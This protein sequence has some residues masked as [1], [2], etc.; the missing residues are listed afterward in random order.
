[1]KRLHVSI[2][3]QDL[4]ASVRFYTAFFDAEPTLLKDDYAKWILDDPRVNFVIEPGTDKMGVDHLGIQ[5]ETEAELEDISARLA[6]AEFET[7]DQ[8]DAICCYSKADKYW[9]RDPQGLAWETFYTFGTSTTY[10]KDTLK[11]LERQGF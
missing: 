1:M 4:N 6:V 9:T 2:R 10:G 11:A 7:M 8:K 5:A 3:V